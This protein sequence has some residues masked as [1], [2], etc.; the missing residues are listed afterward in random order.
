MIVAAFDPGKTT[1]YAVLDT[2][3]QTVLEAGPLVD[4]FNDEAEQDRLFS[5]LHELQPQVVV[6][7]NYLGSG[8][9]NPDNQNAIQLIGFVKAAARSYLPGV[10]F[11]LQN[12]GS[13]K[14]WLKNASRALFGTETYNKAQSHPIDALAHAIRYAKDNPQTDDPNDWTNWYCKPGAPAHCAV[15]LNDYR[16]H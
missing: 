3:T 5:L 14:S 2:T 7:E 1:G 13:R 10:T 8:P 9:R 12:P 11:R 16:G 4:L 15:N 6:C